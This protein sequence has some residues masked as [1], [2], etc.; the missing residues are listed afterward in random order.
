VPADKNISP[1]M[2]RKML[3]M[4]PAHGERDVS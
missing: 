1:A 4:R 2:I 3:S